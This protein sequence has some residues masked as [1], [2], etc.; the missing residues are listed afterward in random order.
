MRHDPMR[1][2]M[3]QWL[4]VVVV[5]NSLVSQQ[6]KALTAQLT[7]FRVL[8]LLSDT[9]HNFQQDKSIFPEVLINKLILLRPLKTKSV[10]LCRVSTVYLPKIFQAIFTVYFCKH[11][12][13]TKKE[14][15]QD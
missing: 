3:L 13:K 4:F 10:I 9:I 5:E 1:L 12:P 8:L 2:H 6:K 11:W 15:S 7:T 14:L